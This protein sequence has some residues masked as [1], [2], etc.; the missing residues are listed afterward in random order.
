MHAFTRIHFRQ[1]VIPRSSYAVLRLITDTPG[2]WP[3]HCHIGWHLASMLAAW[4]PF[5][6]VTNI[7]V[8][9]GRWQP[10]LFSP[11]PSGTNLLL[12]PPFKYVSFNAFPILQ[13]IS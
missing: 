8:Q 3:F 2:V 13:L 11:T 9:S 10:S 1:L 7:N 12:Q 4:L 5:G 6:H